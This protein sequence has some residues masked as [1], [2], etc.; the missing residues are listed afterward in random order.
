MTGFDIPIAEGESVTLTCAASGGNPA[1]TIQW[2]KDGSPTVTTSDY[3]F[4]ANRDLH[5]SQYK[6]SA[7]NGVST[8]EE[9]NPLTVQ[10]K[11]LPSLLIIIPNNLTL[12]YRAH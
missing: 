2:Y 7:T 10:C 9:T 11:D 6:C 12:H 8:L 5:E 3:T 1:A 4:Q